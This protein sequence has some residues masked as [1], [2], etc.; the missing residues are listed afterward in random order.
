MAADNDDALEWARQLTAD[1]QNFVMIGRPDDSNADVD[2]DAVRSSGLNEFWDGLARLEREW[3]SLTMCTALESTSAAARDAH[4]A[5]ATRFAPLQRLLHARDELDSA[6]EYARE[7][8]LQSCARA[9]RDGE[10][11]ADPDLDGASGGVDVAAAPMSSADDDEEALRSEAENEVPEDDVVTEQL[12]AVAESVSRVETRLWA[13]TTDGG[14]PVGSF[15]RETAWRAVMEVAARLGAAV[16]LAIDARE[17]CVLESVDPELAPLLDTSW[18]RTARALEALGIGDNDDGA[19][20]MAFSDRRPGPQADPRGP[21]ADDGSEHDGGGPPPWGDDPWD[22]WRE[23]NAGGDGAL[24]SALG[25]ARAGDIVTLA[26]GGESDSSAA[27]K[28]RGGTA[29][30]VA[31]AAAS[32][33]TA[34]PLDAVGGA[35]LRAVAAAAEYCRARAALVHSVCSAC[36]ALLSESPA[37]NALGILQHQHP[38]HRNH[39]EGHNSDPGDAPS[40]DGAIPLSLGV[41]RFV[42]ASDAMV[43]EADGTPHAA[44][45]AIAACLV[46]LGRHLDLLRTVPDQLAAFENIATDRDSDFS[47]VV[48]TCMREIEDVPLAN[49]PA[50]VAALEDSARASSASASSTSPGYASWIFFFFDFVTFFFFFLHF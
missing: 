17:C 15:A 44:D 26:L 36:D 43:V 13:C 28:L 48:R 24:E 50:S 22:P 19:D 32:S 14:F 42:A 47:A 46:A 49:L 30:A 10:Y 35:T 20:N 12:R 8:Y 1:A 7:A 39:D 23:I 27:T 34:V 3:D 4:A 45:P 16:Q 31:G 38:H 25:L 41:A 5:L 33:S 9:A 6:V 18:A 11:A 29:N 21:L 37:R 40:S 2:A